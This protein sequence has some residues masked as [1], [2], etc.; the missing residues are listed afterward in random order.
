MSN[1]ADGEG[2]MDESEVEDVDLEYISTN[3]I[4][5]ANINVSLVKLERSTL[6][7]VEKLQEEL[8]DK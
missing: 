6:H 7:S 8:L 2:S 1:L 3:L 5:D 4:V